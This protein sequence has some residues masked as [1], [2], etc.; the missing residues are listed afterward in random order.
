MRDAFYEL[1]LYP[2]KASALVTELYI[3]RGKEPSICGSGPRQHERSG[4]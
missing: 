3:S 1:V 2:T 4:G